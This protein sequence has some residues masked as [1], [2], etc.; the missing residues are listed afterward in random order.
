VVV[1]AT[2]DTVVVTV[3]VLK[4]VSRISRCDNTDLTYTISKSPSILVHGPGKT[5]GGIMVMV[6]TVGQ[7]TWGAAS[8]AARVTSG[9]LYAEKVVAVLRQVTDVGV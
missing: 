9:A 5:V 3:L 1:V 7:P 2:P 4:N 8:R 6:G